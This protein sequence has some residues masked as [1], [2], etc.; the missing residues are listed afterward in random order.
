MLRAASD[1]H[2]QERK[3]AEAWCEA[4]HVPTRTEVDELHR[5][6]TELRRELRRLRRAVGQVE[7]TKPPRRPVTKRQRA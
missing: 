5:T 3:M 7:L 2:L 1:R 4:A 6:V